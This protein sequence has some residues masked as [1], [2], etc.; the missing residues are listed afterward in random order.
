MN[1]L[2]NAITSITMQFWF[3]KTLFVTVVWNCKCLTRD[4]ITWKSGTAH[5]DL[6]SRK[7]DGWC[8]GGFDVVNCFKQALNVWKDKRPNNTAC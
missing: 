5:K 7:N 2:G 6:A 1:G 3:I 8:S 4:R